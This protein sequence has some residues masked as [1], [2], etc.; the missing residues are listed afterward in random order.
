[1]IEF[2]C[3]AAVCCELTSSLIMSVD[4]LVVFFPHCEELFPNDGD[5]LGDPES[6]CCVRVVEA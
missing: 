5:D 6:A 2:R 1:M 4:V 3:N